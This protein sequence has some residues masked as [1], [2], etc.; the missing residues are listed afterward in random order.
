MRE[1]VIALGLIEQGDNYLLQLRGKN[2][3]IG[4]AGLI[5]CFGGKLEVGEEPRTAIR[6][7]ISEETSHLAEE[8]DFLHLG[9]VEVVSDHKME[10]VKVFGHVFHLKLPEDLQIEAKEGELISLA[11]HEITNF[12]DKMT[13]GTR[14]CFEQFVIG[15]K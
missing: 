1:M 10:T 3:M 14:A 2:P 11:R 6:R 8:A 5:G 9:N 12:L 4:G 15:D 7:E 13:T